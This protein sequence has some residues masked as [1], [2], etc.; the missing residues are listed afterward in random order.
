MLLTLPFVQTGWFPFRSTVNNKN[1]IHAC[2]SAGNCPARPGSDVAGRGAERLLPAAAPGGGRG[3]RAAEPGA[4]P[5]A[6]SGPV[7]PVRC[8]LAPPAGRGGQR[9]AAAAAA[10]PSRRAAAA[11]AARTRPHR[12][13]GDAR[14]RRPL[15]RL[16]SLPE[17]R[18]PPERISVCWWLKLTGR[19]SRRSTDFTGGRTQERSSLCAR[20]LPALGSRRPAGTALTVLIR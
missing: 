12:K 9:G 16:L 8:S 6:P 5:A 1:I 19:H 17:S 3:L 4:A 14:K 2:G 15:R 11:A 18:T 20:S 13:L 7:R 10:V